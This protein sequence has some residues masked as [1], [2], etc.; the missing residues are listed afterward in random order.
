MGDGGV[1]PPYPAPHFSERGGQHSHRKCSPHTFLPIIKRETHLALGL[2]IVH[3]F[4]PDYC[5]FWLK[6]CLLPG[7]RPDTIGRLTVRR[8]P[9]PLLH[10][11]SN[12]NRIL[13]SEINLVGLDKKYYLDGIII[14]YFTSLQSANGIIDSF[15]FSYQRV[16]FRFNIASCQLP[17]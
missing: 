14:C 9:D 6:T 7:F 12:T 16:R 8:P 17:L 4:D 1:A 15:S 5:Y 11:L 3:R 13:P 2:A 10:T